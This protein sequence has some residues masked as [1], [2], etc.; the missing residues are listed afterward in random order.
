M[1]A[2][3]P[4]KGLGMGLQALLGEAGRSPPPE[5]QQAESR[6]G[7]REVDISRIRRNPEQPRMQFDEQALD[8]LAQSI[9]ER[10]V[11]QPILLRDAGDGFMIVAGERRWRAAQRA[12][13]HSIPAI[14][15]DIDESTIAELAL[16]ENIQ[17]EDLNPLEEAQG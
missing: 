11:L 10:G 5:G 12:Q 9:R 6:A 14:V 2:D 15:R 4:Q 17:R 3:R 16:I 7:V 13:L 1:S 8:E